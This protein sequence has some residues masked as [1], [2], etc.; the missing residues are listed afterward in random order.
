MLSK[1]F[2]LAA[3]LAL[4]AGMPLFGSAQEPTPAQPL[5]FGAPPPGGPMDPS[6]PPPMPAQGGYGDGGNYY[7]DY[8]GGGLGV[9]GG[10]EFLMWWPQ[11]SH[12][13]ALIN[14]A[15]PG[16]PRNS[17]GVPIAAVNGQP[18]TDTLF[19][20]SQ[21]GQTMQTGGRVTFG[22][23]FDADET[24]GIGMR[25]YQLVGGGSSAT[26]TSVAGAPI[27]GIPFFN[28][29]IGFEDALLVGFPG[30]SQGTVKAEQQLDFTGA[31]AFGR[32]MLIN[33]GSRRLDLIAGYHFVRMDDRLQIN[34]NIEGIGGFNNGVLFDVQDRFKATNEF[35]G[36]TLGF[37]G[38]RRN[39]RVTLNGLAKVSMGNN[40]QVVNIS[41][42]QNVSIPMNP[43]NNLV[44]GLFT[45][46]TNIG[47][48][49]RDRL[50]WI[51]EVNA[52]LVFDVTNRLS[53]SIGY[54]GILLTNVVVAGDQ[55]DR[56]VNLSQ[57]TGPLVG[58]AR[59][60]FQFADRSYWIQGMNLGL[61]FN[62]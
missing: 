10:V 51:P 52:N 48:Y 40:H 19:G 3:T 41:G 11:G 39:G 58:P 22:K 47:N 20:N 31:E 13:P 2:L 18:T 28:E 34:S 42:F 8:S 55:L 33:N 7:D 44:G 25:Y 54:T 37:Q 38:E 26:Y 35:H 14:T 6:Q 23:W 50:T 59:P 43:P 36:G 32:L 45:Q 29:Q 62:F 46:G 5:P 4:A 24:A 56:N 15:D 60:A 1:R 30:L 27:L 57:Q 49:S 61:N 9:W 12:V 16:T 53:F 21:L 17:M